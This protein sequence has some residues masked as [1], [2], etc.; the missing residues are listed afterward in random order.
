MKNLLLYAFILL[1]V[2]CSR[3]SVSISDTSSLTVSKTNQKI[4]KEKDKSLYKDKYLKSLEKV[5]KKLSLKNGMTYRIDGNSF[6]QLMPADEFT[7][8]LT[9]EY[10]GDPYDDVL[11]ADGE[12][13]YAA[14]SLEEAEA[15]N[16]L[17]ESIESAKNYLLSH[18]LDF[19]D[20]WSAD[21]P[22]YIH[23]ANIV[24]EME[25][26]LGIPTYDGYSSNL[27]VSRS[28]G[29]CFLE[30]TGIHLYM[31]VGMANLQQKEC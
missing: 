21:S 6:E 12:I 27:N 5:R 8:Y 10:V 17:S 14:N 23:A 15:K 29:E 26:K 11:L 1:L 2:S 30:A 28:V 19:S 25:Q 18:Q 9:G 24:I 13:V 7:Y 3:D 22:N 31:M 16:E 4:F 20:E